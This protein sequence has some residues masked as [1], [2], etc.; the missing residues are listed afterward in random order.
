MRRAVRAVVFDLDGVLVDSEPVY[1]R[2]F[3]AYLAEI[4]RPELAGWYPNTLGRRRA[5]FAG[6]LARALGGA[7]PDAVV[8]GLR[9]SVERAAVEPI[10]AMPGV[11]DAV[12]RI[13]AG[14]VVGLATSSGR[15]V[16]EL[17]LADL[18]I[19]DVF[20]ALAT[21]DEVARGKPDPELYR[22][23]I[24]RLGIDPAWALAIEDTPAGARAAKAAGLEVVA[25]PNAHTRG[26]DFAMADAVVADL[27][28]AAELI[29]ARPPGRRGPGGCGPI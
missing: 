3:M 24:A 7:D 27:H 21:G 22:L 17:V 18:A 14:R 2:A 28:A 20:A 29:G 1:E 15:P 13:A 8:T 19:Q 12:R 10:V 6:A 16:A 4:G 5:D 25:I 11:P 9:A 23:A 26:M